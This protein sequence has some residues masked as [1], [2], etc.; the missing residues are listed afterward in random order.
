MTK[1][2]QRVALIW[3]P[4]NGRMVAIAADDLSRQ[5]L[6]DKGYRAGDVCF[7][8]M[9]KP[10]NPRFHRLIH[11]FGKLVAE[12]IDD[13]HG[14]DAHRVLKRIQL[15]S[16]IGCEDVQ[17]KFSGFWDQ[18]IDWVVKQSGESVRPALVMIR[19]ICGGDKLIDARIPQSLAF[20]S[21]DEGEFREVARGMCRHIA[22]RYW[23]ECTPE[24]VAE[25]AELSVQEAA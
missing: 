7:A 13:F 4:V 8:E 18:V 6:K 1:R 23:P 5:R 12:N 19:D 15:E 24:E 20:E 3:Q 25:M 22:E 11:A 16:G 21:M 10:R 17:I 2:K 14:M 9:V